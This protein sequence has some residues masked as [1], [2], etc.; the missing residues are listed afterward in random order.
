ARS[1]RP[2]APTWSR[3]G[4]ARRIAA[5]AGTGR[6]PSQAAE[7]ATSKAAATPRTSSA[8]VPSRYPPTTSPAAAP[9]RDQPVRVSET[10]PPSTPPRAG[11]RERGEQR[12]HDVLGGDAAE[13]GVGGD[14]EAVLEDRSRDPLHVVGDDVR[15]PEAGRERAGAPLQGQRAARARA[16]DEL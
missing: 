5:T 9:V 12:R 2:S 14:E 3:S 7:H 1:T 15:A 16:Q 10:R 6:V 13:G 11:D 8:T 4:W